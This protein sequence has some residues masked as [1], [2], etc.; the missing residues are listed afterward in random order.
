[1][2]RRVQTD[3]GIRQSTSDTESERTVVVVVQQAVRAGVAVEGVEAVEKH[4]LLHHCDNEDIDT[5]EWEV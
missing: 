1:M 2:V 5:Y 3:A 4:Q